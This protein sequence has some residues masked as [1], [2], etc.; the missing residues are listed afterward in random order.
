MAENAQNKALIEKFYTSFAAA[1]AQGMIDGYADDIV[2]EDP[3][4]GEIKGNDAKKMWRMLMHSS[5][6]NIKIA[7]KNVEAD[8]KTGRADW[9]AH[10]EFSATKRP[11]VNRVH[12][13]FEFRNGKI[14][15]HKDHFSMWKWSRQAIGTAGLLLGW[16]PFFKKKINA[17]TK[18]LLDQFEG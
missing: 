12:A 1:D 10:Y 14:I 4:F 5:G 9:T 13:E 11:V 17:R 2:F 3:A 6:G 8:D 15:K 16:T 18:K 7:F